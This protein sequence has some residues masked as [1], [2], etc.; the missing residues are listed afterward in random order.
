MQVIRI[1]SIEVASPYQVLVAIILDHTGIETAVAANDNITGFIDRRMVYAA[2]GAS[3]RLFRD[4]VTRCGVSVDV[5]ANCQNV[6]IDCK[7]YTSD[8]IGQG[9]LPN[10]RACAVIFYKSV[11]AA[12]NLMDDDI[13]CCIDRD[14]ASRIILQ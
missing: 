3:Q 6:I 13:S 14:K 5:A 10:K 4:Q 9:A 7:E 12:D 2:I 1:T 11:I 8:R